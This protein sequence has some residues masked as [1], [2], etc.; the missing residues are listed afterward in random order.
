MA[1]AVSRISFGRYD[2]VMTSPAAWPS[3]AADGAIGA[4]TITVAWGSNSRLA[5]VSSVV[6]S[7]V[8]TCHWLY[9]L[10]RGNAPSNRI[11]LYGPAEL[12]CVVKSSVPGAFGFFVPGRRPTTKFEAT[13][14]RLLAGSNCRLKNATSFVPPRIHRVLVNSQ[15]RP[16]R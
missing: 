12:N 1:W 13:V 2:W 11:R 8:C 16:A 5:K 15:R 7:F 3:A 14:K 6:A 10:A 9:S 4:L